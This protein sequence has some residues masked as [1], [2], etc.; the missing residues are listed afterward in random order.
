MVHAPNIVYHLHRY[1]RNEGD[2]LNIQPYPHA[3]NQ[4][5]V[6][7]IFQPGQILK[8]KVLEILPN[9]MALIKLGSERLT[10]LV[11]GTLKLNGDYLFQVN[12]T[13]DPVH[14]NVL[15]TAQ[16][17]SR[18]PQSIPTDILNLLK[19][20]RDPGTIALVRHFL[21]ENQPITK[22]LVLDARG[23]LGDPKAF[24]EDV[25][26]IDWLIARRLP[27]KQ[28][29]FQIVQN[30][31]QKNG[32]ASNANSLQE[33]L[34]GVQNKTEAMNHLQQAISRLSINEKG[35]SDEQ[36]LTFLR[37]AA[38][39]KEASG[40]ITDFLT[41]LRK[42]A[43]L[44]AS[45]DKPALENLLK[46]TQQQSDLKPVIDSLKLTISPKKLLAEFKEYL[47]S[48][49]QIL[50]VVEQ[51]VGDNQRLFN[52][53]VQRM[54]YQHEQGLKVALEK[55]ITP[56]P[57]DTTTLKVALMQLIQDPQTPIGLRQTADTLLQQIT[58]QQLQMVTADKLFMQLA[59]QIPVL[60]HHAFS[61][62]SFYWEGKKGDD[63]AIDSDHC[64]ILVFLE[65]KNLKET[66]IDIRIQ[67]RYVTI[68][69]H[70]EHVSMDGQLKEWQNQLTDKLGTLNY[71]LVSM[72]QSR[73][74]DP[75]LKKKATNKITRS[76]H[77]MDVKI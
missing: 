66:L 41:K 5:Q 43:G 26:V 22:Q 54:G 4:S 61:D 30:F 21:N 38:N 55:N 2:G 77:H 25:K 13:S 16:Y 36:I 45:I 23:L 7:G 28:N 74:I 57:N 32:A 50:T 20:H 1:I 29:L 17:L 53:L 71:K 76:E 62:A 35:L 67:E 58:G 11:D 44:N 19:L 39:T 15:K 75:L 12:R 40:V 24:A 34:S 10:A 46:S 52:Q 27:L 3:L 68:T 33:H 60:F 69:V 8:G 63:G 72:T 37:E 56:N 42:Q 51:V 9:N 47:V 6:I 70:N 64:R 18:Q 49:K 73:Q 14:L 59:M 48:N 65:L 31:H